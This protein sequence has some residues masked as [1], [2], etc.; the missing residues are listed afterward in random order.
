MNMG[1]IKFSSTLGFCLMEALIVVKHVALGFTINITIV[2]NG[3]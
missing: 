2:V 1:I 3:G